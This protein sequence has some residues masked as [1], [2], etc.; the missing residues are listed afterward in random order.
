MRVQLYFNRMSSEK[1]FS[2]KIMQNTE[3]GSQFQT[4]FCFLKSF[5]EVKLSGQYL[6][7][8]IFW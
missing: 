3:Q 8:N 4:S 2:L 6:S 5:I 1:Y 7:F